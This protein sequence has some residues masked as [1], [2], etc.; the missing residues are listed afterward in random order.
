[1]MNCSVCFG[2]TR[3]QSQFHAA[4][5]HIQSGARIRLGKR[6]RHSGF[7]LS[8]SVVGVVVVIIAWFG[9]VSPVRA[10]DDVR[11]PILDDAMDFSHDPVLPKIQ[12]Q[13]NR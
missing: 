6:L 12:A 10:Q 4:S 13:L 2:P 1:M 3:R 8:S 9:G 7:R 5:C 11:Q